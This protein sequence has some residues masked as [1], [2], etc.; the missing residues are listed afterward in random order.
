MN[1]LPQRCPIC[2][3]AETVVTRT[4][5]DACESVIEGRFLPV[6]G[7]FAAL[8]PEQ[9]QFVE[10]FVRCEGKMN[11]LEGDLN[12]SYPTLRTRLAEI[13][14]KMGYEPG[15]DE[16]EPKRKGLSED[17]RRKVLDDLEAGRIT[18]DQAMKSLNR[19]E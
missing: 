9:L 15:R 6:A 1:S 10:A 14:R 12:L 19:E 3:S 16:P 8:S 18:P 4:K 17:E 13:I 7:A 2:G 11:R 5:C